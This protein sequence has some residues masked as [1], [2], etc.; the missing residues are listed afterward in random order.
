MANLLDT[1]TGHHS[2]KT[3]VQAAT[4]AGVLETLKGSDTL[5]LLAPTDE[6]FAKLPEGSLDALLQDLPKL[7]KVLSYHVL[8]GDVRAED[9]AQTDEAPTVEGS[10]VAVDHANGIKV[11]EATVIEADI[12]ADNG[13]IH[14]IDTVLMPAIV[15]GHS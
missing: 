11:N 10:V 4:A 7:Q 3:L 8:Y 14:L 13:T 1:V 12:L 9:L 5:T 2:L 6:A 15:A